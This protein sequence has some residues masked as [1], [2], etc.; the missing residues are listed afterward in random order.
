MEVVTLMIHDTETYNLSFDD[1]LLVPADR[2]NTLKRINADISTTIGNPN[3]RDAWVKLLTPFIVAPMERISSV[4]ILSYIAERGGLG[5]VHRYQSIESRIAQFKE[6]TDKTG[7]AINTIEAQDKDLI[8]QLLSLGV[9]II[10][11]DTALGH[12]NLTIEAVKSLRSLVPSNVHIMCGN[13][14][15]FEAYQSL[16]DAGCDSVRVGI[17]GGSACTTRVVTGFGVPTLSSVMDIYD[18]LDKDL[19]NGIVV[20]SG[21]RNSGDIVKSFAAGG[22]AVMMGSLFAGHDECDGENKT[23]FRGLASLETQLEVG[24]ATP[25]VEGVSG[26]VPYRGSVDTTVNQL[27]NGLISGMSYGAARTLKQLQQTSKYII[28]SQQVVN[29]SNPRI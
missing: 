5:F 9:K 1:I 3:N 19:V 15:S 24:V 6:L 27:R 13:V 23:E 18:K 7:F 4:K 8:S 21:I 20:D 17:G 26:L 16:M 14:S 10:V 25:Y 11:I 22:S 2:S 29:E 12:S 28:V